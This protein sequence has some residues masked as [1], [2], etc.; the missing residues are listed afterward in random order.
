MIEHLVAAFRPADDYTNTVA[1]L[2]EVC[3]HAHLLAES[4]S[5]WAT[6]FIWSSLDWAFGCIMTVAGWGPL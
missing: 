2:D 6:V 1:L 5:R 3:I 4:L